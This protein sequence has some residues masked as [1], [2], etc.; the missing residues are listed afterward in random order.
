MANTDIDIKV[1]RTKLIHSGYHCGSVYPW[2]WGQCLQGVMRG[3]V[4]R[5]AVNVL[6]L[7]KGN[8]L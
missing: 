1:E 2:T 4:F 8:V 7:T 6:Y 3:W 5:D